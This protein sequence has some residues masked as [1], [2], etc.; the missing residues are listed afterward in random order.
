MS[1]DDYQYTPGSGAPGRLQ[2][3][4]LANAE[5]EKAKR[6]KPNDGTSWY[7]NQRVAYRPPTYGS[8]DRQE[9]QISTLPNVFTGQ[10]IGSL[11]LDALDP[12]SKNLV[13][14]AAR[15]YHVGELGINPN[16]YNNSWASGWWDGLVVDSQ[17]SGVPAWM[18]LNT[19]LS[20]YGDVL[21]GSPGSSG[22]GGGGGFGGGGP[23]D[24]I[25]LTN[26]QDAMQLLNSAFAAYLGRQAREDEVDDFLKALN[27]NEMNNPARAEV[28]GNAVVQSGGYNPQAFAE[29][30]ARG[31]EGSAEFQAATSYLNNFL[32]II[33]DDRGIVA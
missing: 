13:L 25:R 7:D 22:G 10:T 24:T 15:A 2:Q 28:Q 27:Q 26:R 9:Q 16:M 30:F 21:A 11:D 19:I 14:Q 6:N 18:K 5:A 4:Y 29:E 20:Q 17:T 31:E 23:S 32:S 12:Y 8:A 1:D 3:S 33:E